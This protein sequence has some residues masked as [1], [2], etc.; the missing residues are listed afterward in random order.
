M[1]VQGQSGFT[2]TPGDFVKFPNPNATSPGAA[3]A[4]LYGVYIGPVGTNLVAINVPLV[5]GSNTVYRNINPANVLEI[6]Q[7]NGPANGA[8]NK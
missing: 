4:F 7:V 5:T 2:L 1:A 6:I 3:N 8:N